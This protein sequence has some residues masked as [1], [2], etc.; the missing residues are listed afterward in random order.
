MCIYKWFSCLIFLLLKR[1]QCHKV[2][3]CRSIKWSWGISFIPFVDCSCRL[4]ASH[5]GSAWRQGNQGK[6]CYTVSPEISRSRSK[7]WSILVFPWKVRKYCNYIGNFF[8]GCSIVVSYTGFVL[9]PV[10][11]KMK[12]MYVS[13]EVLSFLGSFMKRQGANRFGMNK[14]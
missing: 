6:L 1:H 3:L 8:W 4:D 7:F 13:T 5:R 14:D 12:G 2:L 9:N 11:G 10:R